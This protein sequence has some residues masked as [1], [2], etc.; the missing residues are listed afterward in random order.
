MVRSAR[1]KLLL[2]GSAVV[3]A[4]V[5]GLEWLA[6]Q[7]DQISGLTDF[8]APMYTRMLQP[9]TPAPE[10]VVAE[11]A[12]PAMPKPR[13]ASVPKPPASA[14]KGDE[15]P[16]PAPPE[17]PQQ[18][19]AAEPPAPAASEP[20]QAA[21]APQQPASAAPPSQPSLD[22][23]PVDTRLSYRLDGK[24]R[25]GPLFGD[26]RV[27]WLREGTKY[28]VKLDVDLQVFGTHVFRSQGEV[29][30][31]G[32]IPRA[33]E[34]TGP[35][36]RRVTRI[37]DEV[38]VLDNGNTEPRPAGVQDTASQFV[39]LSQRFATGKEVLEVGRSV[40]VWLARP[41][42]V[43]RWTY[44]VVAL[45]KISTKMGEVEAYH[46]KP[47]V[48][49]KP[50]GNITAEMWFAPSLQYLPVKIKVLMGSEAYL[51]LTVDRIEQR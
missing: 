33:Y 44:D 12:A 28:E 5:L 50:R 22:H 14:A 51:D 24:F 34:E 4:H 38:I 13:A 40:T 41:G 7:A 32:L 27:Q 49:E 3:V 35:R 11:T 19:A 47:R 36:K 45:E 6:R 16:A 20:V 29:T 21:A 26:A 17:P 8:A 42:G 1:L 43:N 46:L 39:E 37:G 23:W 25:S 10:A 18:P 9:A 48:V 31:E 2:L 30:P 15:Q